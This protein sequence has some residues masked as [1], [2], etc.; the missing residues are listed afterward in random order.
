MLEKSSGLDGILQMAST[1]DKKVWITIGAILAV[2]CIVSLVK[3]AISLAITLAIIALLVFGA[4][5]I[6]TNVLEA[7]NISYQNGEVY[8]GEAHFS[9]TQVSGASVK[10]KGDEAEVTVKLKDGSSVKFDV[11]TDQVEQL[12]GFIG[13][14]TEKE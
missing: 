10:K 13:N 9:P 1:V 6:N 11:P 4:S 2:L 14:I 3:K 12:K 7:N 5:Y 8:I